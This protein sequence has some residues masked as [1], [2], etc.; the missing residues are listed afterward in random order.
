MDFDCSF[1]EFKVDC[2]GLICAAIDDEIADLVFA[3]RERVAAPLQIGLLFHRLTVLRTLS[4][5]AV[6]ATAPVA[7]TIGE[8]SLDYAPAALSKFSSGTR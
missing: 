5:R 6:V 2:D 4:Q 1:A 7:Q 8:E 3:L